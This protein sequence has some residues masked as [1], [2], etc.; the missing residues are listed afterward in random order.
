MAYYAAEGFSTMNAALKLCSRLSAFLLILPA[1]LFFADRGAAQSAE[2]AAKVVGDWASTLS[3]DGTEL[4][5][6]LHIVAAK[7]GSLSSTVDSRD[8]GDYGSLTTA[9]A[10]KDSKL[11]FSIDAY[12]V[13]YEGTLNK[14]GGEIEGS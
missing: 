8:Q 1:I 10:F 7:D 13:A 11:T 14:D 3:V 5:L 12:H 4:H 6:A 2:N 9:T